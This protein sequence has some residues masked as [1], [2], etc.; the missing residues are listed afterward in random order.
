M[1]GEGTRRCPRKECDGT[2]ELVTPDPAY[3]YAK[4]EPESEDHVWKVY[5]C[6]NGHGIM[7][8]WE[9]EPPALG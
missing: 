9:R 7:V 3:R 4:A 5:R 1:E 6:A 8:F 2:L